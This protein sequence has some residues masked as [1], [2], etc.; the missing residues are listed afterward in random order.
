MSRT[1]MAP[2]TLPPGARARIE[3]EWGKPL[4]TL[5]AEWYYG[6]GWRQKD[7]AAR[8][9]VDQPTVS[10]WFRRY[11]LTARQPQWV[12]PEHGRPAPIR[13]RDP[14]STTEVEA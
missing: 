5:L 9:G 14:G 12:M 11:G 4:P 3:R 1:G 2:A 13:Q 6:K 8:L 10:R 7:I